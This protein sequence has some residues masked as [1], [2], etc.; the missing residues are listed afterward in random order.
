MQNYCTEN[1]IRCILVYTPDIDLLKS[2]YEL[3]FI[4]SYMFDITEEID[5]EFVDITDSIKNNIELIDN[6]SWRS[7]SVG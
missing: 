6:L 2:G 3:N 7:S 4:K 1:D 5:M